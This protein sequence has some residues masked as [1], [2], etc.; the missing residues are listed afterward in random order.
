MEGH[1]YSLA[2]RSLIEVSCKHSA[3]AIAHDDLHH[4]GHPDDCPE[5]GPIRRA[6]MVRVDQ[7]GEALFAAMGDF[8]ERFAPK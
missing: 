4:E 8:A 6:L 1:P 3:V 2:L 5:C 7:C